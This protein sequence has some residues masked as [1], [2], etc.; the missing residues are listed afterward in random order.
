MAKKS[1]IKFVV[2]LDEEKNPVGLEWTASDAPF[3]GLRQCDA[4]LLSFWDPEERTTMGIDLWTPKMLVHHMNV[5]Y[6]QTLMKLAD[7]YGTA[8]QNQE[9]AEFIRQFAHEF[10]RRAKLPGLEAT[11][12]EGETPS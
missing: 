2:S 1:E 4:L 7:T 8:T 11:G 10:A 5:H 9:M 6:F 12:A 3:E